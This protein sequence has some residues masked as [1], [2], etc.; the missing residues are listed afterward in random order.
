M[1]LK[2]EIA[3]YYFNIF[4]GSLIQSFNKV[5]KK[6]TIDL[7]ESGMVRVRHGDNQGS[8][9]TASQR[10]KSTLK[11]SDTLIRV[12]GPLG[13]GKVFLDTLKICCNK[14]PFKN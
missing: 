4:S 1:H 7:P 5:N 13:Q 11:K 9:L 10:V 14:V 2:S 8:E 6:G 12:W 3:Y